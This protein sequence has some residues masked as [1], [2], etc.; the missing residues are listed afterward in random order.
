MLRCFSC[1]KD[2]ADAESFGYTNAMI[3]RYTLLHQKAGNVRIIQTSTPALE[4]CRQILCPALDRPWHG[5]VGCKA[6]GTCLQLLQHAIYEMETIVIDI[7]IG[8]VID[9]SPPQSPSQI[10]AEVHFEVIP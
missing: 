8:W 3:Y 5:S 10:I 1:H 4:G 9:L 2:L 6:I 7:L